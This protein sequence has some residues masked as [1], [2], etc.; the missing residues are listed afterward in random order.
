M[1]TSPNK[2]FY[3]GLKTETGKDLLYFDNHYPSPEMVS[4]D[5]VEK[6]LKVHI[7]WNKDFVKSVKGH[8]YLY[9]SRMVPCGHCDEDFLAKAKEWSRRCL[10]ECKNSPHNWFLT[11]TFDDRFCPGKLDKKDVSD[12]LKRLR[13]YLGD[14][15]RFFACGELGTK[16][17]RP[18]YHMILFNCELKDLY[19]AEPTSNLCCSKLINRI[20]PYGMHRLGPVTQETCNYVARYTAKKVGD[21]DG[22][23][24][25]SR[26]PGIGFDYLKANEHTLDLDYIPLM[27]NGRLTRCKPPRYAE[28]IFKDRDFTAAKELRVRN[29]DRA[30]LVLAVT[31]G[32]DSLRLDD[33]QRQ[34]A[35]CKA[36]RLEKKG[37]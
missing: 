1:C 30:R 32:V 22:F 7:P 37:I 12:F 4:V 35:R 6:R 29:A 36:D 34:V 18:H 20:W 28:R 19:P 9:K 31:H 26:R 14:G 17:K 11:L 3:T 8:Q 16:S 13:S 27:V 21:K 33:Y 23:L 2:V 24:L 25:M 5:L 10:M 15:V